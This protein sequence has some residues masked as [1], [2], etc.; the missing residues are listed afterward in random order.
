MP[1]RLKTVGPNKVQVSTPGGVKGKGK[2]R[3]LNATDHGFIPDKHRK[4][5]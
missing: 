2:E 4:E 5:K 1:V 3:L